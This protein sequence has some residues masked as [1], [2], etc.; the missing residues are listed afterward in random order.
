MV[1]PTKPQSQGTLG[2]GGG[3]G[4]AADFGVERQLESSNWN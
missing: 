3:A 1:K 2:V 4:G